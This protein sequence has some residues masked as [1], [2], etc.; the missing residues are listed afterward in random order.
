MKNDVL[1][2]LLVLSVLLWPGEVRAESTTVSLADET[3]E[4]WTVAAAETPTT[5][6]TL[7]FYIPDFPDHPVVKSCTLRVVPTPQ[8]NPPRAPQDVQVRWKGAQGEEEQ[9]GQWSA[10]SQATK[11]Y[12]AEL[13]PKACVPNSR[14]RFM[15]QTES[16]HTRWEYHGGA[17]NQPRLIVTY[18]SPAPPRSGDATD[19]RFEQPV[20][21][22]AGRLWEGQMLTNPVSYDGALY[23]VAPCASSNQGSCLYRL[24]GAGNV[25]NWPII[26]TNVPSTV[27]ANSFAFVTTWGRMN[28]ISN[29]A[30]HSCDLP[31]LNDTP[32]LAC[33]S[34]DKEQ[35][36]V[37]DGETPAMGQNGILYF[38][39]VEAGGSLVARDYSRNPE[40][41]ELWRTMLKFTTVSPIV[42]SAN[43]QHAYALAD[44]P[45]QATNATKTIALI[46]IDTAT[47]DTVI[48]AIT[49]C[50]DKP[51][52]CAETDKVKPDLKT[53][54]RP[55]V[56]SKVIKVR[57]RETT[58]D[59]VFVAGN[60]SDTSVLQAIMYEPCAPST[61][62]C[63]PP[64]VVWSET[65][66]VTGAP[67]LSG[68]GNSLYVVHGQDGVVKRYNWYNPTP[69]AT[70]AVVKPV[71][72]DLMRLSKV[73]PVFVDGSNGDRVYI[74]NRSGV[75]CEFTPAG[76]LIGYSD[77][78]IYDLSPKRKTIH[79]LNPKRKEVM[80]PL[81][82]KTETIY[83]ADYVNV[84]A[85]PGVEA[86]DRVILKGNTVIL[87]NEFRW[88][89]GATLQVQSVPAG[90]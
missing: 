2:V 52:P 37:N 68:D 71:V 42:L 31:R 61:E 65:G 50:G 70:G 57:G 3:A 55:T 40:Q 7:T 11:P 19:W 44:I 64:S 30:V 33:A 43:G 38:K 14:V 84:P 85:T 48:H 74:C 35:I 67:V 9:V 12:V 25:E 80:G 18:D 78:A 16:Q 90:Q 75:R 1:A 39:N 89:L 51:A 36:T 24:A 21:Y 54:L 83:S 82:L 47:G 66:T 34:W 49:H 88:P 28:I 56:A 23:V 76:T 8:P 4:S 77:Q 20:G 62:R 46:R 22:F 13:K 73:M 27:T 26:G 5:K 17:S 58:V 60:T 86:G 32:R 6:P 15:L 29:N 81:P 63:P 87:P 53:L 10:D 79:D 45:I 69:T 59:Y 72:K 41:R